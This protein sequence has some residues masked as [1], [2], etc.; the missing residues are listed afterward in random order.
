MEPWEEEQLWQWQGE[1]Q[2]LPRCHCCEKPITTER[3]MELAEFGLNARVCEICAGR[4]YR[5]NYYEQEESV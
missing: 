1:R 2:R 3:Y 5:D 4:C